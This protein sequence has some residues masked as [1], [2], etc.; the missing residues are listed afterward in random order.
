MTMRA[1][2]AFLIGRTSK[3]VPDLK[4]VRYSVDAQM[5]SVEKYAVE[6]RFEI[7]DVFPI[8][9]ESGFK[10]SRKKFNKMLEQAK[11]TQAK[12]DEP[13]ALIF[14]EADRLSRNVFSK[15]IFDLVELS[16]DKGLFELH[17]S[18]DD[19]ALHKNSP[20][21]HWTDFT[22][23]INRSWEESAKKGRKIRKVFDFRVERGEYPAYVPL[24]YL[25]TIEKVGN[26]I[27][28]K[29]IEDPE[30]KPLI[31][32]AF[33][34]YATGDYSIAELTKK[35]VAKGLT[36]RAKKGRK[37]SPVTTRDMNIVLKNR[38][39]IGEF[40]W[41][42]DDERK[43]Y[44]ATNYEPILS[45][46]LYERVQKII[47]K[48]AVKYSTRHPEAKFFKFRGLLTCGFC[49]CSLT[50]TDMSSNYKNK[51]PGESVYYRCTYKKK[52]KDLD[53]YK[54]KFGENHSGVR[55]WRGE[56][57]HN[58]PQNFW[59][60]EQIDFLVRDFL[61]TLVYDEKVYEEIKKKI[62]QEW[63]SRISINQAQKK[64]V[65]NELVKQEKLKK[66]L[67][68][69][70]AE[71]GEF[72]EDFRAEL[73]EVKAEIEKNRVKLAEL[74]ELED[75]DDEH[76]TDL[77]DLCKDLAGQYEKLSDED[78][79]RLVIVAFGS[80]TLKAGKVDKKVYDTVDFKYSEPF[81]ELFNGWL[82]KHLPKSA[83]SSNGLINLDKII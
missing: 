10:K 50:P 12:I 81:E 55:K 9:N 4:Q 1:N 27:V 38:F 35:M 19:E 5:T 17:F 40:E 53:Y 52:A 56:I 48:R 78:K 58:C 21:K 18:E 8:S 37:P 83:Q 54:K 11:T 77:L 45:K 46:K 34:L 42:S 62:S 49:G 3:E 32:E 71:M 20:P 68:R 31:V 57:H 66:G 29:I 64:I 14:T 79:R 2:K 76:V 65:E 47:T 6:K 82:K 72:S 39:Y 59:D 36:K 73:E 22:A 7:V 25:N 74:N 61:Q 28:K 67:I 26:E 80:I 69:G 15:E 30:R 70:M 75:M 44:K 16:R 23:E 60:E 63:E 41:G 51:K 13:L 33:K 24:G 43:I